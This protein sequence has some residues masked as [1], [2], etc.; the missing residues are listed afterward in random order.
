[1]TH[2][3]D[4]FGL[5]FICE[6]VFRSADR[7]AVLDQVMAHIDEQHGTETGSSGFR[8]F[9]AQHIDQVDDDAELKTSSIRPG[10]R[11]ADRRATRI[12]ARI[13]DRLARRSSQ[14]NHPEGPTP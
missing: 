2:T 3:V 7:G 10:H 12:T 5:G 13:A 14:L 1:M 4:C 6:S 9:V 11:R 8:D